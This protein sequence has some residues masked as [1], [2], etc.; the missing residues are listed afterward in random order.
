MPCG[1]TLFAFAYRQFPNL[2]AAQRAGL[3]NIG[4]F[5][6]RADGTSARAAHS[7][8]AP[9]WGAEGALGLQRFLAA[10]GEGIAEVAA[11]RERWI[12][13]PEAWPDGVANR[14]IYAEF[15]NSIGVRDGLVPRL[16][17]AEPDRQGNQLTPE[18]VARH[19]AF[20]PLVA[21]GWIRDVRKRWSGGR[22]PYTQYSFTRPLATLPAAAEAASLGSTARREFAE[23]ILQGLV[24]W[25]DTAFAATV[26]RPTRPIGQQDPHVW[27]TPLASALRHLPWLPV[28]SGD[29]SA[30]EFRHPAEVWHAVDGELPAFL[31]AMPAAVRRLL[32]DERALDRAEAAGLRRWED[33]ANADIALRELGEILDRG[34]VPDHLAATFRNHYA[35]VLAD[36]AA[37]KTWPWSPEERAVLAT[38]RDGQ[39]EA[40]AAEPGHVVYVA[41]EN[42]PLKQS[43]VELAGHRVL[44]ADADSGD[45]DCRDARR[46]QTDSGAVVESGCEGVRRCGWR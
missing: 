42:A 21:E 6:P 22:H 23:L 7:L 34:G 15:L 4:L 16:L 32:A 3:R 25:E 26:R 31:P 20:P 28:T 45:T 44:V 39:L 43:L 1:G 40:V 13:S 36:T 18:A 2:N 11:L 12:A 27:P 41:D 10:G 30:V 33:P 37:S 24:R 14:A 8:M 5:V 35:R 38:V 29:G 17:A 46:A 19:V 9:G